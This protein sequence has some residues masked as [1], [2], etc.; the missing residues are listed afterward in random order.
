MSPEEKPP[1]ESVSDHLFKPLGE[2]A[3][4]DSSTAAKNPFAASSEANPIGPNESISEP[5]E[6]TIVETA[7]MTEAPYDDSSTPADPVVAEMAESTSEGLS[8]AGGAALNPIPFSSIPAPPMPGNFENV[9]ANGGAVGSFVLGVW[10]LAGS[11]ITN[12]SIINGVIGLLM[13]FWGLT[14]RKQRTA[15]IGIALCVIG[16]FLSLIQVSEL[17]DTYLNAVDE[18]AF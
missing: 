7:A 5:F 14:S 18:T 2:S 9:S 6:A 8:L 3:E 16:I 4:L 15:W 1:E 10:C 12:W 11:F 13:G 17:I